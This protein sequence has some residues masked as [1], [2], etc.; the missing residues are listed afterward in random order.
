MI[1][2]KAS[3]HDIDTIA[4]IYEAIHDEEEK[5][6]AVIGWIRNVYPTRKTA[7]DWMK[8]GDLF[9]LEDEGAVVAAAVINLIHVPEYRFASWFHT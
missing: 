3:E 7:E 4:M 6:L 2:R 5:G 1:I 9:V 8:R